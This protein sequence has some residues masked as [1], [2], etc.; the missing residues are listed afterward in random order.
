MGKMMRAAR[1][2]KIGEP[3]QVDTIPVPEVRPTDVLVEVKAAGVVPNL[4]NVVTSYPKWFPFL[5]L[6]ALPAIYGLDA[7]GVV[8]QVGSQVRSGIKEG[9]RVYINPGLSC[10]GCIACRRGDHVNCTAYTFQGYFGFGE[11]SQKLF[12]DY[13]YGGF[14][15]FLTAPVAN[16]VKLPDSISFE[17]G[18]RFGYLGTSYSALKKA[19]FC[20]GQTVL[21][22]GAT[23]T[24]GLGA[25]I[26][27]LA[28]GAAKIFGT[29][30]NKVLLEKLRALDPSRIVPI[31]L[32]EKPTAEVVMAATEG[33]G[34]DVLIETLGPN[35]PVSNVIDSFNALRRGG[36][37]IN[38]GGVA[39]PI[40]LEPFPL[41]CLQKSYIGSLWFT[42]A[43]GQDMADMAA[44]GTLNLG[45]FEHERF[46]LDQVNE[47]LD[48]V[49]QRTGGFTNVVIMH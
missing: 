38:I 16:L 30:R 3:F 13:P 17:Q 48:A 21:I 49:E 36:K 46:K 37:A 27:A 32:G 26:L 40:P 8:S 24:L 11:G 12:E 22:D 23:G 41:M 5:P 33:Y 35:A 29:G 20:P 31:S 28:M 25:V 44:S 4:R 34:V 14:G 47:A 1:L 42:T 45:V 39:D 15:Q 9:D 7:A 19:Q 18:A 10:G 43:E 6:P 2:H